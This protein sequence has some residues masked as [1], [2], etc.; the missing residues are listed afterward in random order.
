MKVNFN[1]LRRNAAA[2]YSRLAGTLNLANSG[3][4]IK[5]DTDDIQQSMDDLRTMI[6]GIM[7]TYEPDNAEFANLEAETDTMEWF[8]RENDEA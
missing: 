1:H 4:V 3:G 2:A 8:N 5:I 6:A 7:C